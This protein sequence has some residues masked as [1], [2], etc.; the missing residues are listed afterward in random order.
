MSANER[1]GRVRGSTPAA[2]ALDPIAPTPGHAG[3]SQIS[4]RRERA[5]NALWLHSERHHTLTD[6]LGFGFAAPL[7][8]ALAEL[9]FTRPTPIQAQAIPP[10]MQGRDL[11][12]V[13]QTGTGKTA[14]FALPILQKLA[15]DRRPAP[16]GGARAL[17]LCP[18]RELASQIGQTFRDL[19]RK[20]PLK[21]AVVFGGVPHGAQIRAIQGGLDVLVATPGRLID[22]MDAGVANLRNVEF[23]VLD[24]VDQMLDLGFLR[25]IQRI[26]RGLPKARQNLFFSATMPATIRSLAAELL[27]NPVEVAVTPAA[28]T[29]DR[30]EQSVVLVDAARKPDMLV[31]LFGDSALSRVIVFTRT[32][33]GA[34]RVAKTLGEAGVESAAIHGNKSQGQRERTLGAFRSGAT[35][36][37]VATD[38]AA[39]G[40]DIDGV[41][42]VVNYELPDVAEAYV[43]RIGRTARAGNSGRAVSL[44]DSG[45][46]DLLR[47]IERLTR[48]DLPKID[49]RAALG[50]KPV[51]AGKPEGQRAR[52][53][54]R[55]PHAAARKP[56]GRGTGRR[57]ARRDQ[58]PAEVGRSETPRLS[59]GLDGDRR[60]FRAR[61]DH[62]A[63]AESK[64]LPVAHVHKRDGTLAPVELSRDHRAHD[65]NRVTLQQQDRGGSKAKADRF[66][67]RSAART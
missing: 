44:C 16:R 63:P 19:G 39:R 15:I 41:T 25:P 5:D 49:R 64:A 60:P 35:R 40:I 62:E 56:G 9:G 59:S 17:I 27:K 61:R 36:V 51:V 10:L 20:L 57:D 23:L 11:V 21:I 43:H 58:R 66:R 67:K 37:L 65:D 8:S 48:L 18:T 24:E 7:N 52:L 30:V 6:F 26:V 38:I 33:R 32:K 55:E 12:G 50:P 29:A 53:P 13:A 3:R 1:A 47:A 2:A 42:H 34:D 31:E 28:R 14:A 45:E 46:R 54:K 22:H 4:S